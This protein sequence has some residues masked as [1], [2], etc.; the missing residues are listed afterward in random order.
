MKNEH[1]KSLS[2]SIYPCCWFFYLFLYSFKF[3]FFMD[4]TANTPSRMDRNGNGNGMRNAN[5]KYDLVSFVCR[6]FKKRAY[7]HLFRVEHANHNCFTSYMLHAICGLLCI[8]IVL[9]GWAFIVM[10]FP[11][12]LIMFCSLLLLCWRAFRSFFCGKMI[13]LY[14]HLLNTHEMGNAKIG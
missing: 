6:Q 9:D 7:S 14:L 10:I 13:D 2:A 3:V 5:L 8:V 4:M 1:I 11:F 12:I